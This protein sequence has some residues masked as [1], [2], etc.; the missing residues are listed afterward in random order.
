MFSFKAFGLLPEHQVP[1]FLPKPLQ[2]HSFRPHI[3]TFLLTI[4]ACLRSYTLL[5]HVFLGDHIIIQ[6]PHRY[7]NLFCLNDHQF[8]TTD[9]STL[10]FKKPC[11]LAYKD[12]WHATGQGDGGQKVTTNSDQL[13]STTHRVLL[14]AGMFDLCKHVLQFSSASVYS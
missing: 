9:T 13:L 6:C 12:Y 1:D 2:E 10:R 14:N 5:Q 8:L 3:W 7:T 11:I 4:S